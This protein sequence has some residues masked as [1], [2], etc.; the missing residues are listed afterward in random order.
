[1]PAFVSHALFQEIPP[2][3]HLA[4]EEYLS[5]HP[6]FEKPPGYSRILGLNARI[7]DAARLAARKGTLLPSYPVVHL[8]FVATA[9]AASLRPE[10]A[11]KARTSGVRLPLACSVPFQY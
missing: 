6:S 1:V 10:K 3:A 11:K 7:K 2:A 4:L 8:F 9:N 5:K